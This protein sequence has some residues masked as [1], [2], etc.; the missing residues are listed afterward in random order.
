MILIKCTKAPIHLTIITLYNY[1][2]S[3]KDYVVSTKNPK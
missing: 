3:K 2:E 1:Y